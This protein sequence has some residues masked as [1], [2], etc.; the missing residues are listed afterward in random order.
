MLEA[1]VTKRLTVIKVIFNWTVHI[2]D[3][4]FNKYLQ[5]HICCAKIKQYLQ[6]TRVGDACHCIQTICVMCGSHKGENMP[7]YTQ[8]FKAYPFLS[9]L[10]TGNSRN[11]F[12]T[13]ITEQNTVPSN[14][15]QNKNILE[16]KSSGCLN[17]IG[18]CK[19]WDRHTDVVRMKEA[20][21]VNPRGD[22]HDFQLDKGHAVLSTKMHRY[23]FFGT[24]DVNK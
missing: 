3:T 7:R 6:A 13:S 18:T 1:V 23:L 2:Y 8:T 14:N 12:L 5:Q 24:L 16:Q 20:K 10:F 21:A 9:W 4:Y 19:N 17:L 11:W 15:Y 22:R